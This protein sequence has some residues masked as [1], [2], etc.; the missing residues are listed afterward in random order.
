MGKKMA[1]IKN[2]I[3]GK[4]TIIRREGVEL[5]VET[6]LGSADLKRASCLFFREAHSLA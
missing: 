6:N 5:I 3:M 2:I 4:Y 1:A